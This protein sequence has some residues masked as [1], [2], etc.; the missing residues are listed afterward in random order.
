MFVLQLAA[1]LGGA[2]GSR[3]PVHTKNQLIQRL[4]CLVL[5]RSHTTSFPTRY[6]L[7]FC[8]VEAIP[9]GTIPPFHRLRLNGKSLDVYRVLFL[10]VVPPHWLSSYC[11]FRC[12]CAGNDAGTFNLTLVCVCC[13]VLD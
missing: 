1:A 5:N 11:Y 7:R 6:Q 3:T 9:E 2:A 10:G 8:T 13:F 12:E 4:T